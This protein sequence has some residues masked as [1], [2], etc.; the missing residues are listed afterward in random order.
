[1]RN[2]SCVRRSPLAAAQCN[3]VRG[4]TLIELMIAM[5]IGLLVIAGVTS[6]F[7]ATQQTYR[8]NDALSDVQEGSRVAFELLSREIRNAGLTGCISTPS[9]R[10]ANVL[11]NGPN[12]G[13]SGSAWY[14]NW[15]DP[16]IGYDDATTDP[17]LTGVSPPPVAGTSSLH[18]L[19]TGSI[20]ATVSW[21]PDPNDANI[22]ITQTSTDLQDGDIVMV[23]NFDHAAVVQIS[24]YNQN[25]VTVVHNSGNG[26]GNPGNCSKGLGFPTT[27]TGPATGNAY[28]FTPNSQIAKLTA[29]AWYIGCRDAGGGCTRTS[30][31][32]SLYRLTLNNNA[33]VIGTV[34]QEMVRNVTDMQIAYLLSPAT[35]AGFGTAASINGCVLAPPAVDCWSMVASAQVKL[36]L[37]SAFQ[38]A[39]TDVKP[40]ARNFISTST[41]RNRVQ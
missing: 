3:T 24:N 39:G 37:Q 7:M 40:L 6:V 30:G 5:T 38:R 36:W 15:T 22:K 19:S 10:V 8:T 27:C 14:A 31:N 25:N 11:A 12:A 1:M 32:K 41:I 16:L 28:S 9:S 21:V 33:G 4:F 17:A 34:T 2:R 35:S 23:C 26:S 20:S 29:H 18:I 13:G